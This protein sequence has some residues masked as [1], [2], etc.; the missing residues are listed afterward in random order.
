MKVEA[1]RSPE[2]SVYC[3]QT[4]RRHIL[5]DGIIHIQSCEN[6]KSILFN[7]GKLYRSINSPDRTKEATEDFN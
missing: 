6:L 2:T 4:T 7:D 3:C 5:E 1:I